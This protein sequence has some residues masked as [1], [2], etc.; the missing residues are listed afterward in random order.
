MKTLEFRYKN[1]GVNIILFS[2]ILATFTHCS[3]NRN[4]YVMAT[5]SPGATYNNIGKSIAEIWEMDGLGK[6]KVLEGKELNS[7]TNCLLLIDRKADFAFVQNDTRVEEFVTANVVDSKI[8]TMLP[9]YPEILFIVYHDSLKPKSLKDLVLGRNVAIG[10]TT[11]GTA[12]FMKILFNAFDIDTNG[13]NMIYCTFGENLIGDSINVSCSITGFNNSRIFNMVSN[14]NGVIYSF[15]NFEL[16]GKGST[17]EGFNMSYPRARHFII[18]KNTYGSSGPRQPVLTI[19][20][21]CVLLTHDDMD[22]Y[23]I[24][25]FVESIFNNAPILSNNNPLL[26][27]LSENFSSGTVNFPLHEG[28]KMYLERN[29]PSFFERYAEMIGVFFSIFIVLAGGIPSLVR[30]N[31][32]RKKDRID[33]YYIRLLEI[34]QNVENFKTTDECERYLK[35]ITELRRNAFKQ[36]INEK[37]IADESFRIFINLAESTIELLNNKMI[38]LKR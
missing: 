1:I 29:E 38:S 20:I 24:K 13:F 19:A 31:K 26:G 5:S 10:P 9:V 17:V 7:K 2:A 18:P 34:E 8:R 11:S 6:I 16:A 4:E 14:L 33:K 37:L 30:W 12:R 35:E 23:I 3:K 21:D 32:H 22:P 28:V 15:D 36:L 25:D 27:S